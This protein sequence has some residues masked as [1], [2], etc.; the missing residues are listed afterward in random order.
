[1]IQ[2]YDPDHYCIETASRQDYVSFYEEEMAYRL[3]AGYPPAVRMLSIHGACQEEAHLQ[4]AM[5]YLKKMIRRV[6]HG[7]DMKLVG[8]AMESIGKIQDTYRM[9]LYL[10]GETAEELTKV[11]NKLEQYIEINEGYRTVMIQ[12]DMND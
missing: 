12:F 8:P 10:K 7:S 5:E 1:M 6:S 2:T 3:I 9:V 4:L 11:K